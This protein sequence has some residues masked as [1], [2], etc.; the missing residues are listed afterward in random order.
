[1]RLSK[2]M[3]YSVKN[4]DLNEF[5][6]CRIR[7]SKSTENIKRIENIM[8]E[9]ALDMSI[10]NKIEKE[11]KKLGTLTA[12]KVFIDFMIDEETKINDKKIK[13]KLKLKMLDFNNDLCKI[14]RK[15]EDDLK[16]MEEL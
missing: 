11:N 14:Q 9:H 2:Y 5:R 6:S 10:I 4:N 15:L 1:M 13:N 7:F 8:K 16:N 3:E 12:G